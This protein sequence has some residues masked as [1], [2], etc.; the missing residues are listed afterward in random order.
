MVSGP[1]STRTA[2]R[3][4]VEVVGVAVTV[5]LEE[6]DRRTSRV[7]GL[8]M[9]PALADVDRSIWAA[10]SVSSCC[11]S[12]VKVS[13]P[14]PVRSPRVPTPACAP[15]PGRRLT[16]SVA[17]GG[18]TFDGDPLVGGALDV[19]HR[20]VVDA[21]VVAEEFVVEPAVQGVGPLGAAEVEGVDVAGLGQPDL[22][23]DAVLGEAVPP[24]A[25]VLGADVEVLHAVDDEDAGVDLADVLHVVA[26]GPELRPVAGAR[27]PVDESSAGRRRTWRGRRGSRRSRTA[28]RGRES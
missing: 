10:Q 5:T 9:K 25:E 17:R 1:R 21:V 7:S 19:G 15:L 22:A 28:T 14:D 4:A 2:E 20:L 12:S 27:G 24:L 8:V 23:V 3:W 11:G 6:P 16:V 26:F 13:V 18:Q